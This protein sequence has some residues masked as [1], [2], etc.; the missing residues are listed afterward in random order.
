MSDK[1]F[2]FIGIISCII[3]L[4]FVSAG[5]MQMLNKHY[6]CE[7]CRNAIAE[8]ADIV[9]LK[10]GNRIHAECYLKCKED[11]NGETNSKAP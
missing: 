2:Y 10:N 1:V 5:S 4:V 6:Q 7:Y 8:N 9:I 3:M 11:T